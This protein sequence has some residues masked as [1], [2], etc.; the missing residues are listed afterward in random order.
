MYKVYRVMVLAGNLMQFKEWCRENRFA[1]RPQRLMDEDGTVREAY[2]CDREGDNLLGVHYNSY[3]R[4]GTWE[5][6]PKALK[7]QFALAEKIATRNH[8]VP[9]PKPV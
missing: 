8:A 2:Y 7:D 6:L 1:P 4:I 5:D 3:T 9:T